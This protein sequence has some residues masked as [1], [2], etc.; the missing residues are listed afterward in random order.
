MRWKRMKRGLS[1]QAAEWELEVKLP[2]IKELKEKDEK[3]EIDLRYLD[4]AGWGMRACIPY[5]WQ[6]KDEPI[7]LKDVDG[8]RINII[9]IMNVRNELQRFRYPSGTKSE[10]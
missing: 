4:Q 5:G 3:G 9:G 10:R 7:I 2:K 1:K 6:D 8:K